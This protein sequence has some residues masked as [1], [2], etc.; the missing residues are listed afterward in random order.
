MDRISGGA[1][2]RNFL[3]TKY[4]KHAKQGNADAWKIFVCFVY[5]VVRK[6]SFHQIMR[7]E[8]ED[9]IRRRI[10]ADVAQAMQF[11]RRLENDSARRHNI[12]FVTLQCFKRAFLDDHQFLGRVPVRRMRR[13]ARIERRDVA[14]EFRERRRRRIEHRARFAHFRR[15]GFQVGPVEDARM[16]HRFAIGFCECDARDRERNGN[17]RDKQISTSDHASICAGE[18]NSV[19]RTNVQ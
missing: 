16:H 6:K 11:I 9:E 18:R 19:K 7:R 8:F 14:L 4:R 17:G 1:F 5:F 13:L 10:H 2:N 3:T 12:C 15:L